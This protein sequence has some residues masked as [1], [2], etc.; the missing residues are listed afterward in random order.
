MP[1]SHLQSAPERDV[2][3]PN[4]I[5]LGIA[6]GRNTK[7]NKASLGNTSSIVKE[8]VGVAGFEPTT[9][10]PPDKCANR[11]ALHSDGG[12]YRQQAPA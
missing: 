12:P 9:P 7:A 6:S 4:D 10:C 2:L 1:C 11:A 5:F 8:M 3:A